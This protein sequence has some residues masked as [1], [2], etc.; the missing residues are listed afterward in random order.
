MPLYYRTPLADDAL[1]VIARAYNAL[2][3]GKSGIALGI[4]RC[5]RY[6]PYPLR[7]V[8]K[9]SCCHDCEHFPQDDRV[10]A[11]GEPVRSPGG[12]AG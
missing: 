12:G 8:G 5:L 9:D 10:A 2:Y 11:A 7:L 3:E 6:G 4:L 1:D